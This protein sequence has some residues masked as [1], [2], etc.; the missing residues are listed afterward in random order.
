M[1][2]IISLGD[3]QGKTIE[4]VVSFLSDNDG[5][6]LCITFSDDT[7]AILYPEIDE[8]E[9]CPPDV[10][11]SSKKLKHWEMRNIGLISP[12]EY[13]KLDAEYKSKKKQ[14][15]MKRD[16]AEFERLKAKLGK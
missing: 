3:L 11:V 13:D 10:E 2:Q 15:E 9:E 16:L 12:D 5:R 8:Y 4:K 6:N 14:E 1:E 7:Y